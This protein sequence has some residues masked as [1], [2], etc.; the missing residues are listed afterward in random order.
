MKIEHYQKTGA[1]DSDV[2]MSDLSTL[3][4]DIGSVAG[5]IYQDAADMGLLDKILDFIKNIISAINRAFE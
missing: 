3:A 2:V 4:K 5:E 1:V